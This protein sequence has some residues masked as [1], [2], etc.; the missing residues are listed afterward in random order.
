MGLEVIQ[1]AH[2]QFYLN[3]ALTPLPAPIKNVKI[4][5]RAKSSSQKPACFQLS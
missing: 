1:N 5:T 3:F 4:V 2:L